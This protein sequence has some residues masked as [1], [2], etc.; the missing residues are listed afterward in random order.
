M[1]QKTTAAS[2]GDGTFATTCWECS[3]NCGALATVKDGRVVAFGPNAASPYSKG[4]FCVKG[5]RGAPG[6]TYNPNR[7]LYPHRRVAAR[8]VPLLAPPLRRRR[9]HGRPGQADR[10]GLAGPGDDDRGREIATAR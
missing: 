9:D 10:Q 1:T 8:Q 7:L 5:I 4:A 2:P 6:L 3:A